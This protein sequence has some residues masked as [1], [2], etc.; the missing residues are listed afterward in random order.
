MPIVAKHPVKNKMDDDDKQLV[1]RETD[2]YLTM[3]IIEFSA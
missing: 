1:I 3:T 2:Y